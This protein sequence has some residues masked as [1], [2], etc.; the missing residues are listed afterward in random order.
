MVFLIHQRQ[1]VVTK[2]GLSSLSIL[3][4]PLGFS[5]IVCTEYSKSCD[6]MFLSAFTEYYY[7]VEFLLNPDPV[8]IRGF[9]RTSNRE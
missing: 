2:Q 7:G 3:M 6:L 5:N 8:D 4:I 1:K 9:L